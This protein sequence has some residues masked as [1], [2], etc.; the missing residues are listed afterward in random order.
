MRAKEKLI[1]Q[2]DK[3]A[4]AKEIDKILSDLL[5]LRL[6]KEATEDYYNNVLTPDIRKQNYD[7]QLKMHERKNAMQIEIPTEEHY[8]EELSLDIA[9]EIRKEL[10]NII[11]EDK[12]FGYLYYLLGTERNAK[13]GNV[14]ID[15]IP[16][17]KTI[18]Q[19]IKTNRDDYPKKNLDSYLEDRF[20]YTQ[21]DSVISKFIA[22]TDVVLSIF[23][24]A[25]QVFDVVRCYKNKVSKIGNYLNSFKFSNELEKY[26]TLCLAKNLFDAFCSTDD[27]TYHCI[28]E[29]ERIIEPLQSKYS[30]SS[31][32][33][34][35]GKKSRIHLNIQK[36]MKLDF[37]RVLNAMYEKGFFKDEQQNK[38]S[39]K[40]VFETFG[41]CLNMD[42]SKFQND[43]SR[44]LTDSTALEKHLKVF[45]DLKDKMEEIFNS[46]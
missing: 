29:I 30:E 19:T 20:N 43:L 6:D 5:P 41:E 13:K 1:A 21:Y 9:K 2:A 35:S 42:L 45:E 15:C 10:F 12:S 39:K 33:E 46:R 40:E 14:P 18:K 34:C 17:R 36:G 23:N 27:T 38:I 44:S 37:I 4:Y 25:Y 26:L 16:N 7:L 32:T 8:Q 11:S 31:N 3:L 22:D 24:M 28:R